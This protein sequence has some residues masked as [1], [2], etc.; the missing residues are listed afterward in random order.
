MNGG[1]GGHGNGGN[2]FGGGNGGGPP[3]GPNG[4][5]GG[6]VPFNPYGGGYVVVRGGN[7]HN[8]NPNPMREP[9]KPPLRVRVALSFLQQLNNKQQASIAAT[10]NNIEAFDGLKPSPEE[11]ATRASACSMLDRYFNGTLPP[12]EWEQ[13]QFRGNPTLEFECLC[14][15]QNDSCPFCHG[16]S[17]M[18]LVVKGGIKEIHNQPHTIVPNTPPQPPQQRRRPSPGDTQR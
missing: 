6:L 9:E 16:S 2:P 12:D 5:F 10:E 13:Q 4:P 18:E 11:E 14:K 3:F 17:K 7:D 15:G 8:E 1:Q